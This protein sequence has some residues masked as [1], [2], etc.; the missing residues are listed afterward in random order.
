[1]VKQAKGI[2]LSRKERCSLESMCKKGSTRPREYKRA[3]VLLLSDVNHPEQL[4]VQEIM[5]RAEVSYATVFNIRREFSQRRMEALKD[6][7][8]PG[9]P[10]KM[11]GEVEAKLVAIS[12]SKP[13]EGYAQWTMR[14]LANRLVELEVVDSISHVSVSE[15]LKKMR[16]NP[17][18]STLG[19][20]PPK[21]MPSL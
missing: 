3:R 10:I 17:G 4:D 18:K 9:R 2:N 11:T 1:M 5:E 14:M 7:P 8:R 16:S 19:A 13:P 6:K 12:C 21:T 15:R 20:F